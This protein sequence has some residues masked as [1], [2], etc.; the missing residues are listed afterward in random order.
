MAISNETH[1]YW[2]NSDIVDVARRLVKGDNTKIC[3]AK[4]IIEHEKL[5][6]SLTI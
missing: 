4:I 1:T 2:S 3:G 6:E 5:I